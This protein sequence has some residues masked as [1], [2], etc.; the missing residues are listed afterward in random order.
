MRGAPGGKVA[1]LGG[2]GGVGALSDVQP[3]FSLDEHK[4]VRR[5]G[6]PENGEIDRRTEKRAAHALHI[7]PS[8]QCR[9]DVAA[10][11]RQRRVNL[12]RVA[13]AAHAALRRVAAEDVPHHARVQACRSDH[14]RG[15]PP[16][17]FLSEVAIAGAGLG[18]LLRRYTIQF[19]VEDGATLERE[20]GEAEPH[21]QGWL[22]NE[23]CRSRYAVPHVSPAGRDV[24][25]R[26][27]L[28]GDGCCGR[29]QSCETRPDA[30]H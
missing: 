19:V 22:R 24:R 29:D 13:S 20:A 23:A 16:E 30:I 14:E 2:P 4:G 12:S 8:F 9:V 10:G 26:G 21:G 28:S 11:R 7:P 15:P 5:K 3:H 27:E 6:P 25:T 17:I 18:Q 1:E